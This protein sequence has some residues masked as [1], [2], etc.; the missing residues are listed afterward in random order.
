V[1]WLARIIVFLFAIGIILSNSH[2]AFADGG[3]ENGKKNVSEV[4][5]STQKESNSGHSESKKQMDSSKGESDEMEMEM[6][7]SNKSSDTGSGHEES[8][9]KVDAPPNYKVLGTYGAV[10]LSFI[11]IG[12]WNKWIR[13]KVV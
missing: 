6:G 10:N 8:G 1:A 7:G 12:I 3:M 4:K 11:L 13:R 2:L 9:P 5:N